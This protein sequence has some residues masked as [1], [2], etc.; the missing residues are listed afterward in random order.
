MSTLINKIINFYKF[1]DI[2]LTVV[3]LKDNEFY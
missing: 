3:V 2:N 1:N